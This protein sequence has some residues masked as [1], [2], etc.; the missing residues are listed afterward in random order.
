[1]AAENLLT[2][3]KMP[4]KPVKGLFLLEKTFFLLYNEGA[5]GEYLYGGKMIIRSIIK[6]LRDIKEMGIKM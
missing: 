1:M 2:L 3:I 5:V 4:E 6:S